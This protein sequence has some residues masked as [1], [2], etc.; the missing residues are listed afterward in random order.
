[1]FLQLQ[2]HE[3]HTHACDACGWQEHVPRAAD[4]T[5]LAAPSLSDVMS[6][7][8]HTQVLKLKHQLEQRDVADV[9]RVHTF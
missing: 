4:V 6:A 2:R 7:S 1:M 9:V 3:P 5:A 8:L